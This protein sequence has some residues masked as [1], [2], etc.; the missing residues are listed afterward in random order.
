ME[1]YVSQFY[2]LKVYTSFI[3]RFTVVLKSIKRPLCILHEM[4]CVDSVCCVKPRSLCRCLLQLP[5]CLVG[6]EWLRQLIYPC[7]R[8]S[9]YLAMTSRFT[10][11]LCIL[12]EYHLLPSK[13]LSPPLT[14]R[15]DRQTMRKALYTV[16]YLYASH[17]EGSGPVPTQC[18]IKVSLDLEE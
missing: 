18:L 10:T 12:C 1:Q 4:F 7:F 15:R 5:D 13:Q 11:A 9:Q 14:T 17:S 16:T 6:C 2:I 3:K 8:R